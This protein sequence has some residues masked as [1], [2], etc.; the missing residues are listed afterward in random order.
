MLNFRDLRIILLQESQTLIVMDRRSSQSECRCLAGWLWVLIQTHLPHRS[1]PHKN[2]SLMLHFSHSQMG[3]QIA[4]ENLPNWVFSHL[5]MY[6]QTRCSM[7]YFIIWSLIKTNKR[8]VTKKP[9]VIWTQEKPHHDC[10][11]SLIFVN[12]AHL[13]FLSTSCPSPMPHPPWRMLDSQC[14]VVVGGMLCPQWPPH[15]TQEEGADVSGAESLRS[16]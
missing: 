16:R 5:K 12:K 4:I 13:S 10:W 15:H 3:S 2:P 14:Q 1:R 7:I 11:R 6:H 8:S 9:T